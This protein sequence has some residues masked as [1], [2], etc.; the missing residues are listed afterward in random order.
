[1]E[2]DTASNT[3]QLV[4]AY[5]V[6]HELILRSVDGKLRASHVHNLCTFVASLSLV[7]KKL[8]EKMLLR[9]SITGDLKVDDFM[10]LI[11]S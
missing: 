1:M 6:R 9:I 3:E 4:A 2:H 11:Y 8:L 10:N 5:Q 7:E